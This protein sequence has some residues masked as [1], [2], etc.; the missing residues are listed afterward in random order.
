MY[1]L[2]LCAWMCELT[3]VYCILKTIKRLQTNRWTKHKS[4]VNFLSV[5]PLRKNIC[6]TTHGVY[7]LSVPKCVCV[8]VWISQLME[9]PFGS[10][11]NCSCWSFFRAS[12]SISNFRGC[13]YATWSSFGQEVWDYMLLCALWAVSHA[14]FAVK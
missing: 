7:V 3:R 1:I 4:L 13:W 12:P 9:W 6:H 11:L 14:A 2:I 8:G 10:Q 5:S